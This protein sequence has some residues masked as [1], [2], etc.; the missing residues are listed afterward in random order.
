MTD[1][2]PA[3]RPSLP[4]AHQKMNTAFVG[5]GGW[6]KRWPII[7][8]N[9]GFTHR[10]TYILFGITTEVIIFLRRILG[11]LIPWLRERRVN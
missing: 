9:A 1:I 7:P 4:A 6:E 10:C 11:F 8:E 3:K 5:I 2:D